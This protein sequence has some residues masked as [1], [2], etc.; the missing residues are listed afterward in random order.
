MET[1]E[2]ISQDSHCLGRDSNWAPPDLK[3][4]ALPRQPNCSIYSQV[5]HPVL[6]NAQTEII[7]PYYKC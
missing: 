1:T 4:E 2:N 3:T 7:A 6:I 5:K